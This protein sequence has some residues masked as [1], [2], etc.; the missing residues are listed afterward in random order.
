MS[1]TWVLYG[2]RSIKEWGSYPINT[3]KMASYYW[4]TFR[5]GGLLFH[6][7]KRKGAM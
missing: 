2:D 5:N 3:A 7:S 4:R 6:A 1:E